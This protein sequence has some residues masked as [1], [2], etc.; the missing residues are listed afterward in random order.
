VLEATS[1]NVFVPITIGGGIRAYTDS[2]GRHWSALDAAD[3]YFRA[4]ADKI[5]I[6]SE[7]VTAAEAYF[8]N[9]SKPSGSSLLEQIS[10]GM[11]C[12]KSLFSFWF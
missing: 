9:G 4:G 7:A 6:G 3:V 11:T 2:N 12:K 1:A 8:A 10:T 5:S